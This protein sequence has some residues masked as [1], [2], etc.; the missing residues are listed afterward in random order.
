MKSRILNLMAAA[1]VFAAIGHAQ[2]ATV[3]GNA[4]VSPFDATYAPAT[5]APAPVVVVLRS[6]VKAQVDAAKALLAQWDAAATTVK[7]AYPKGWNE[8]YPAPTSRLGYEWSAIQDRL[9]TDKYDPV[10]GPQL[11]RDWLAFNL[12]WAAILKR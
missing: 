4:T 7:A 10:K 12:E 2:N 9:T 5:P 11:C 3:S 8:L 6:P 1:L